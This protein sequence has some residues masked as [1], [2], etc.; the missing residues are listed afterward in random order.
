MARYIVPRGGDASLTLSG[1]IRAPKPAASKHRRRD[2]SPH[3]L[4]NAPM[5]ARQLVSNREAILK[6]Y[7]QRWYRLL[8]FFLPRGRR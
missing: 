5:P 1:M 4:L 2:M 3:Y 8:Y 6:A 7:G